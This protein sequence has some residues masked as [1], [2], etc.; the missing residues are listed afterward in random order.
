MLRSVT[1]AYVADQASL[2]MGQHNG[3]VLGELGLTPGEIGALEN[4]GIRY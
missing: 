2:A 1:L 4:D 3:Y